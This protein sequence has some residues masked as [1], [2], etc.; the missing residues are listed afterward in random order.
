MIKHLLG[1]ALRA[2]TYWSRFR[3][4]LLRAITLNVMLVAQPP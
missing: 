1:A 2:R 4:L 3:E